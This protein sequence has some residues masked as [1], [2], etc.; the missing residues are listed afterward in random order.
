MLLSVAELVLSLAAILG[1]AIVFT[2]AV[3]I[4]GKRLQLGGGAVGSVLAA[5]GTALPETMIPLIAILTSILTGSSGTN[6]ISI[7]AI[8]G[9]PF[10]LA[11]L[12]MFVVGASAL[13]FRRHRESGAEISINEDVTRRDISYFLPILFVIGVAGFVPLPL[14]AK[15]GLALLLVGTYSYYV[16]KTVTREGGEEDD[17]PS[18]LLLWPESRRGQAP[19]WAVL[20]QVVAT[21]A[22]MAVGAHYFVGAVEQISHSLG[23]PAGLIALILAPLATELPEKFNSVYWLRDNKDPI[24]VGN[25]TG[26]MVFQ[27]MV[28]VSLGLVF[29]P[30]DFD[31]RLGLAV[32]LALVSGAALFVMLRS[33]KPVLGHY[34]LYGGILYIGFVAVAVYTAIA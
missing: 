2:N 32:A 13:G 11:T 30:W 21:I 24:A 1:A 23:I 7:G 34:L 27:S 6:Q 25:V 29:T 10:L 31:F 16:W 4:L 5:A 17:S 14:W 26:A 18:D 28:P 15:V 12:G 22:V 8:I 9:A 19:T 33:P 20:T 3:E